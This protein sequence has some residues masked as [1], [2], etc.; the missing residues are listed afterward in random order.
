MIIHKISFVNCLIDCDQNS[1]YFLLN[2]QIG[3]KLH[4][5]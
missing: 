1:C 4:L 5:L 2:L 3:A